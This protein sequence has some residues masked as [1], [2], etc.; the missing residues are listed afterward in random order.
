M[1]LQLPIQ[2][3]PITTMVV[4]LNHAHGEV[5]LI[6][7]YVIKYVSDLRQVSGYLE[8]TPVS[9]TNKG[10]RHNIIEILLSGVK[11]H[12]PPTNEMPI[13]CIAFGI[14][15]SYYFLEFENLTSLLLVFLLC[16]IFVD[17]NVCHFSAFLIVNSFCFSVVF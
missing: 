17:F 7:H 11:H 9:S 16:Y 10:D 5:Y 12:N 8:G 15:Y 14:K 2:S 6:Q 3:V 4:S 1:D 13:S